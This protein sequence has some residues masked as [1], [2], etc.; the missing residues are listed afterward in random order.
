MSKSAGAVA[1]AVGALGALLLTWL[2]LHRG[3]WAEGPISD[4]PV[5]ERYGEAMVAGEVP[6]RD[7]AVEYPPGALPVFALPTV[8]DGSDGYRRLFEALMWLCGA[9]ALVAM[10]VSLTALGRRGAAR[11]AP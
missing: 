3:F 5:Y 6:Y 10:V 7:F 11:A 8:G 2:L 4:V 9:A 1:I